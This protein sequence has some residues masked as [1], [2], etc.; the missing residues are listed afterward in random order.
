MDW[1]IIAPHFHSRG[2]IAASGATRSD[3][4]AQAARRVR[5]SSAQMGGDGSGERCTLIETRHAN[6]HV[7]QLFERGMSI[8]S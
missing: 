7:R 4:A 1:I 2:W 8:E 5:S 6:D 3:I